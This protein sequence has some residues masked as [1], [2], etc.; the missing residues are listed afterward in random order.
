MNHGVMT[1]DEAVAS[2]I[3][4]RKVFRLVER[5]DWQRL[6]AGVYLTRRATEPTSDAERLAGWKATL[7]GM[8]Q[9][10]GPGTM[11]SHRSA[12]RLHRLEG[13]DG[14]PIDVTIPN[15]ARHRPPGA[16]RSRIPDPRAFRIDGLVTTSLARTF[17]DLASV[18]G[19]DVVEQAVESALRGADRS[20]PDIW[21]THLLLELRELVN[22]GAR[23]PGV[24]ALR[25]VLS[26][27][28]DTDRPTGSFPETL[29]FQALRSLGI[30]AVRQMT[31]RIVDRYGFKLDMFFPDLCVPEYRLL[32]EVDGNEAHSGGA[33]LARDLRRQNKLVKAF[34]VLRFTAAEVLSDPARVAEQ[35]RRSTMHMPRS[36][37]AWRVDDVSV[38]YTPNNFE[39]I[40]YSRDAKKEATRRSRAS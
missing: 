8:L 24:F 36:G 37:P 5:G 35:I 11:V 15:G 10:G 6:H 20:R 40:D 7:A 16:H 4:R 28:S 12:A 31:L 38:S 21:N 1:L 14:F 17:R 25:T 22:N 29:L 39:V 19:A 3:S 33:A 27:R 2:G 18:C 23:L 13:I 34:L 32:I 30:N 9:C 26:R